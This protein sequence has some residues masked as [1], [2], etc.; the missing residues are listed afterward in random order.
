[1]PN[2]VTNKI[3]FIGNQEHINTILNMIKGEKEWIDFNKIVP[4][5]D[6]IYL[7]DLGPEERKLYGNRNWYDWRI[8][9]WGT[10]WNAYN[11][12]IDKE[13]N[14]IEFDTAWSCPFEV[15]HHLA[16]MCWEYGVIFEG[17]WADEDMGCNVGTFNTNDGF[18]YENCVENDSCEAYEIYVEVKGERECL[19]KND[20]GNWQRYECE[21]CP[22]K[23]Y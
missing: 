4:M 11:T 17:K 16:F 14:T 10:K 2:H 21:T 20:N 22:N 19:Y 23:C 6:D 15:L 3:T 18:F 1:M 12:I 9:N 7:G 13:N 5:P 8:V